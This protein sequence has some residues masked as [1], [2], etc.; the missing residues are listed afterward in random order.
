MELNSTE[1]VHFEDYP[2]HVLA[3]VLKSFFRE[4]PEP[5][6]TFDCYED[7]L[8]ATALTDP[9]DRVSTLFA[10]LKKLPKPNFDL[11]E[12][13]VFHLAR[14]ASQEES[15]RMSASALAIVF[16]PCILR[17]SKLLP[18]QDSL[19]DISKQTQCI[20]IIISEQLKKVKSTLADIDTL[21]TACH[22]ASHRLSSLRS[23]KV[24]NSLKI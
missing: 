15:N 6:L 16:A 4:M 21:D 2:V 19:H 11:M 13:L 22:T 8:R 10:I 18:A 12:R 5:L 24:T 23:S 20:E 17:T 1:P 9:N 14:V 3:S 7:F